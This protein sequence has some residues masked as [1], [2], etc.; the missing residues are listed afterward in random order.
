MANRGADFLEWSIEGVV[1]PPP[2]EWPDLTYKA[3]ADD[4]LNT[5]IEVQELTFVNEAN[6]LIR[7]RIQSGLV[8]GLGIFEGL[9][10]RAQQKDLIDTYN[11]WNGFIDLTT[12][13]AVDEVT[14]TCNI[15]TLNDFTNVQQTLF[16]LTY[17]YLYDIDVIT[18][19]DFSTVPFLIEQRRN[20]LELGSAI[21][22]FIQLRNELNDAVYRTSKAIAD[23]INTA[24]SGVTGALRATIY[25]AVIAALELA[26]TA[27][28][29]ALLLDLV[30]EWLKNFFPPL[31]FHKVMSW[32]DLL[33]KPLNFIGLD[34]NTNLPLEDL[35]Y[36]PSN[37]SAQKTGLFDFTIAPKGTERGF[38]NI[39]EGAYNFG[40]FLELVEKQFGAKWYVRDGVF[41]IFTTDD[42]FFRKKSGVI[43]PGTSQTLSFNYNADELINTVLVEYQTDST[44]DFTL[45]NFE[46]T[47][48]QN[49]TQPISFNDRQKVGIKGVEINSIPICLGTR[50]GELNNFETFCLRIAQALED[51]L[52]FFGNNTN[53]TDIITLRVGALKQSQEFFN[54]P[55]VL[56]VSGG[57]ITADNRTFLNAENIFNQYYKHRSFVVNNYRAQKIRYEG[58]R[59]PFKFEDFLRTIE[60]TMCID[61]N[62]NDA[63]IT[64][65]DYNP[66]EGEA[67]ISYYIERPFTTSLKEIKILPA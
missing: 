41:N 23:V 56:K 54:L 32:R 40:G 44:D 47:A 29:I 60:N 59:I 11:S 13:K 16:D 12:F 6:K 26:Y 19:S 8:G 18:N 65:I 61:E 64:S 21:V 48:F 49:T 35:V 2:V 63:R 34:L 57:Q 37:K 1:I 62:G 39:T 45:D 3:T 28:I 53:F 20:Y 46:G 31:G 15:T 4:I 36:L 27:F 14:C 55:K 7:E 17:G 10:L 22:L 25:A 42:D 24:T 43:L 58:I 51:L 33:E 30:N 9:G 5:D 38:P 52:S 50:K 67:V 66:Y